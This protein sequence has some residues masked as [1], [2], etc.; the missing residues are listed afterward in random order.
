MSVSIQEKQLIP[1]RT[2]DTIC[3]YCGTG[4]GIR[5]EIAD[6]QA[7]TLQVQGDSEHPTNFGRLCSKGSNLNETMD[8]EARLLH[9]EVD[10]QRVDWDSALDTT[11]SRIRKIIDE[12]G[13][14]AFA[15]YCSG[16]LLTEDYY[17][18]NKLMK[19]FIG[20]ANIDTNS[21]LCMSSTVAGHKRAFGSDTVPGCY[22]DLDHAELVI[23]TGSNTAWCHPILFQRMR[24]AKE[25]NPGRKTVVIDPRRTATCDIADLHL[26]LKPGSDA[27]LFNGLLSYLARNNALNHN[28][29]DNHTTGLDAAVALADEHSDSI[30]TVAEQCGLEV[31]SVETFYRWFMET[32]NTVTTFSQGINQSSSGSDKVNAIINCHL[33]TGRIGKP[34]MGPLSFTGQPNAMGGR[35]VG[36]LANQLAAHMELNNPKHRDLLS[37][38]WNTNNLAPSAGLK[39]VD[40]FQ[41]IGTGKVKG[42]WIIATNPVDSL[43][44]AD[45]VRD[46]LQGCELVIQSDC[47]NETDTTPFAHIRFPALGWGEKDGTLTNSERRI[48]RQRAIYPRSGEA[49]ADWWIISRVAQ[50][51][52]FEE[53]FNYQHVA[54]VFDE[55]AR[56]SAFENSEQGIL[57]DFNLAGMAGLSR[58]QYEQLQPVQWP[59]LKQAD[60]QSTGTQRLFG[61]GGFFTPDRR[62]NFVA[63]TPRFP[64]NNTS[65]Q[66]P[67]I[68]NT[69]RIRDQWHTMTRTGLSPK[70]SAHLP[71]PFVE[72]HPAEAERYQL[73][74]GT[75]ARL[76]SHWGSMLARVRI[77]DSIGRGQLFVPM[78]WTAQFS[79]QGR[80]GPLVNPVV[81]PVSGQPESKHT[82][83]SIVP[84]QGKWFGFLLSR[85]RLQDSRLEGIE[86]RVRSTGVDHH[87][88]ELADSNDDAN[89]TELL[90]LLGEKGD[91]LEYQDNNQQRFR[92]ARI[93]DGRLQ[94]LLIIGPSSALPERDWLAS[95]FASE[96]LEDVERRQLLSG[97]PPAGAADTGPVVCACFGVG[98]N[99]I[100]NAIA[101][102]KLDSTEAVGCALKAGTNCGSCIP[103]IRQLLKN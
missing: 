37:R 66:Y 82:P 98:R 49:H 40:L 77:T 42:V 15:I 14:D 97:K 46:A 93:D 12:H 78:H 92:A 65:Q 20:S 19:G 60:Q 3:A 38:F 39:A 1:L 35:E 71:E 62:A 68:L 4:C 85:Q 44:D 43:P 59:V 29:I 21:R 54:E 83:T 87:R 69:G 5:V 89:W 81:D 91:L 84:Y 10:G 24:A 27:F 32:E 73:Q 72:I 16:Q 64:E 70:L 13:P 23:L 101:E 22:E 94:S 18:A 53:A 58:S 28:Y 25:A 55:H 102:Q 63:V 90:S 48:S 31:E 26:A 8:I 11:A 67:L 95:L 51:L 52:G 103:E 74:E 99:T 96:Q 100:L 7:Q 33:A 2:V 61:E 57:R 17:V 30:E 88:Y 6:D 9:P 36:G 50:K 80:M 47:M 34:G 75:I 79:S 45:R 41:A 56:L 76:Q 86:Y